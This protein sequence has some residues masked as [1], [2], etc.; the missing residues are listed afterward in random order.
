MS[1]LQE[2][3]DRLAVES[4]QNEKA[5]QFQLLKDFIVGEPG[6]RTYAEVAAIL[7]TTPAAA[8]MA[9]SRMRARYRQLL[10]DAIAQTVANADDIDNEIRG[11]F[12]ALAR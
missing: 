6:D 1:L 5:N 10:R 8:K 12:A 4:A 9:A 3:M 2:V 11:L 7:G